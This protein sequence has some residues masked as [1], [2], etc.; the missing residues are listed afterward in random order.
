[1]VYSSRYLTMRDGVRIAVDLY[2]PAALRDGEKL[3]AI[4]QQTRYFRSMELRWP[5]RLF[6]GGRPFDHT[7]LYAKRRKRFVTSGYAWVVVDV[8]GSGASYGKPRVRMVAGRDPRRGG[9]RGLDHRP[10]LVERR[11]RRDGHLLR[12][13][14]RGVPAGQQAPRSQ[15]GG[16]A[17]RVVRLLHR[18]RLPRRHSRHLAHRALGSHE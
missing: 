5:Y 16:A 10:T 7:G 6:L 13:Q 18:H 4:L 8:R 12:W 9:D 17:L 11:G 2:L 1:M 15:G 14:L 3:P